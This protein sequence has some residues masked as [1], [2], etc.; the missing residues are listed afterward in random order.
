MWNYVLA[1][2]SCQDETIKWCWIF[3]WFMAQVTSEAL[4]ITISRTLL[5]VKKLDRRSSETP[6]LYEQKRR[7]Q[8]T[9]VRESSW[10]GLKDRFSRKKWRLRAKSV[11]S[12]H[13]KM[14]EAILEKV[15]LPYDGKMSLKLQSSVE[16]LSTFCWNV[17]VHF[18]TVAQMT[19]SS[20]YVTC[21]TL[22]YWFSSPKKGFSK[23]MYK[24]RLLRKPWKM[25]D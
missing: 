12:L 11:E 18:T 3:A 1:F 22:V 25:V 23:L 4:N 10:K 13:G 17:S 14:G 6:F 7:F 15:I 2:F 5:P 20:R 8:W 24:P 21:S 16:R 9:R 19:P